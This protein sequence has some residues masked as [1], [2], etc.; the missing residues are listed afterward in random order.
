MSSSCAAISG[1]TGAPL[2]CS[3]QRPAAPT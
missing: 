1:F 2:A 3:V